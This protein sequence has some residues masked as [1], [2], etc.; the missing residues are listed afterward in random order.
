MSKVFLKFLMMIS[1]SVYSFAALA[2][3][4]SCG[5]TYEDQA[6]K[7]YP[8]MHVERDYDPVN[9]INHIEL[10]SEDSK[11]KLKGYFKISAGEELLNIELI[12][13]DNGFTIYNDNSQL[14]QPIT[15]DFNF[16]F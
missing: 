7:P 11:F 5:G 6:E 1:L 15:N 3:T 4:F 10:N 12:S 14:G 2:K 8:S 9:T 13:K 16:V